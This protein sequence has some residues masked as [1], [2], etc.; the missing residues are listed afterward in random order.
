MTLASEGYDTDISTS[1]DKDNSNTKWEEEDPPSPKK[2][3]KKTLEQKRMLCKNPH[4]H[5]LG[6]ENQEEAFPCEKVGFLF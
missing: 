5:F 2:K 6:D 3:N 4:W 1:E